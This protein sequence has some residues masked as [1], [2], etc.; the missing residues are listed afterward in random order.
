MLLSI[1][2]NDF[3]DVS[4]LLK[5]I[6]DEG[7]VDIKSQKSY[8]LHHQYFNQKIRKVMLFRKFSSFLLMVEI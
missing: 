8:E 6:E 3:H 5:I 7:F 4:M 1:F 2:I